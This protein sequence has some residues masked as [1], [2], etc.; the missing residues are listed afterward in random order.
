[1]K[2]LATTLIVGL[3]VVPPQQTT[4]DQDLARLHLR[5]GQEALEVERW[6]EAERE[7]LTALKL[8]STLDLAHHGLGQVHMATRRYSLAVGAFTRSRD[9]FLQNAALDLGERLADE[10]RL[11]NRIL[12]I[13]DIIRGLETGRIRSRDSLA[14]AQ[15]YRTQLSQ[16]EAMRRRNP[17]SAVQTPPYILTALGGAYFRSGAFSD[18][19]REWRLAID[20]DPNIGEIHNNLAVVYMLTDRL[21]QA[22]AEITLAEKSGFKVNPQLKQDLKS[23]RAKR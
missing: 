5:Q 22:E 15:R 3:T 18:A 19:E 1:M 21:E 9:V 20:I 16:L 2:Y 14:S 17:G 10:R 11:D 7:F 13:R 23:Q 8:D 6:E 4:R 12:E